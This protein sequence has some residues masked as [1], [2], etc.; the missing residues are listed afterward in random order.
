MS[1]PGSISPPVWQPL[2]GKRAGTKEIKPN[3]RGREG[4]QTE[5]E[6]DAFDK[7]E[8]RGTEV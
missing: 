5:R 3:A 4:K 6:K 2:E 7:R 8:R 1:A